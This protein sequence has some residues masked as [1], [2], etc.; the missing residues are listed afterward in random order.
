M[1]KRDVLLFT[2]SIFFLAVCVYMISAG[3][4]QEA[5]R[6]SAMLAALIIVAFS[7]FWAYANGVLIGGSGPT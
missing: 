3:R 1:D 7:L 2:L 5:L 6:F 4:I